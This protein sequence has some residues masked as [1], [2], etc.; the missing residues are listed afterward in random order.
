MTENR[1]VLLINPRFQL[2]F[3]G[4]VG[5]LAFLFML[6]L[7]S[8]DLYFF[9]KFKTLG[10]ALLLS[11]DHLIFQF[12][13][14]QESTLGKLFLTCSASILIILGTFGLAFSNRI[15]GPLYQL[16][17]HMLEDAAKGKLTQVHFRK[18]DFFKE[19]AEAYNQIAS[20][21]DSGQKTSKKSE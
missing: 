20:M 16:R 1:K 3:L 13:D 6:I 18:K 11:S 12:L 8:V 15:A 14:Y 7:F 4:L 21:T 9:W 17:K 5:L 10:H 2:T 19:I